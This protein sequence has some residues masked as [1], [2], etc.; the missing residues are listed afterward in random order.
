MI[1][2]VGFSSSRVLIAIA[3][4]PN[5]SE[6]TSSNLILDIARQF[7]AR[8]FPCSEIG[9]FPTVTNQVAQLS[10]IRRRDKAVGD[11]VVLENVRNPLGVLFVSF[12]AT[13]CFHIFGVGKDN[14]TG[15]LQNVKIGIQY[16]PADS[17]QTSLQLFSASHLAQRR[18]SPVKVEKRLRL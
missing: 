1:L 7:C 6:N 15:K 8:F 17:M 16:F 18:R 5:T 9:E 2:S 3:A 11:K 12:L 10:N 4:L 14:V 13:N